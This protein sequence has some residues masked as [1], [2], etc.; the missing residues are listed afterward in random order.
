MGFESLVDAEPQE[1]ENQSINYLLQ[2]LPPIK[3]SAKK[4]SQIFVNEKI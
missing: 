4:Y 3:L 1:R 2:D